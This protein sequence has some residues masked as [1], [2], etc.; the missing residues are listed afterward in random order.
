MGQFVNI[1]MVHWRSSQNQNASLFYSSCAGLFS[2]KPSEFS[3]N[4]DDADADDDP[5]INIGMYDLYVCMC[6]IGHI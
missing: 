3:M 1:I 6:H 2:L 5:A 4:D